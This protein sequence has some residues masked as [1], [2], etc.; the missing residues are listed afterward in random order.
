MRP[1]SKPTSGSSGFSNLWTPQGRYL[2]DECLSRHVAHGLQRAGWD[3]ISGSDIF[4]GMK[5]P[6]V[7]PWCQSNNRAWVTID[8]NARRL[9]H[10]DLMKHP[11]DVLWLGVPKNQAFT[12]IYELALLSHALGHF[13][14]KRANA[15]TKHIHYYVGW[16]LHAALKEV[17]GY[18][19]PR[20]MPVDQAPD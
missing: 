4:P 19:H 1:L 2:L 14:V 18:S 20:K 12:P 6:Q 9:H 17:P 13:D 11:I 15:T 8:T 7:I 10:T 5:D 16:T 3:I